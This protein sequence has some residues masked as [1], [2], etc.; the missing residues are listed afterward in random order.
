MCVRGRGRDQAATA[1]L[2]REMDQIQNENTQLS[3]AK[4]NAEKLR[5]QASQQ[6]PAFCQHFYFV[7]AWSGLLER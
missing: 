5:D 2:K 6:V 7:T 4:G 3:Y 1:K